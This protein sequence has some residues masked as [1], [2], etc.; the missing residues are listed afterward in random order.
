MQPNE[1]KESYYHI[2]CD[3]CEHKDVDE[4][5]EPCNEC[6]T[7][8]VNLYTHRPKNYKEAETVE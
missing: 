8:P 5:E 3:K 2:Y 4:H 7:C 6:L 1:W